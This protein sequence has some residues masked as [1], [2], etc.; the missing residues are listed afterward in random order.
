MLLVV[1]ARRLAIMTVAVGSFGA[2]T[3]L[4]CSA[5][6]AGNE[7]VSE[8]YVK[9]RDA[10][11]DTNDAGEQPD[12]AVVEQTTDPAAQVAPDAGD[13]TNPCAGKPDGFAYDASD[14]AARCCGGDEVRVDSASNCGGCGIQCGKGFKCGSPVAG[15]WGCEC[16]TNPGCVAAGYGPGA[17]CYTLNGHSFCNCQCPD[18]AESCTGVCRGGGTC[19][20][21]TGQN[22]CSVK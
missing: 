1:K 11:A 12:T 16:S 22:Y 10:A 4:A 14:P 2:M 5:D 15:Q 18:G 19:H 9:A 8:E 3:S 20:D 6:E 13:M 7:P 17:T 21:V